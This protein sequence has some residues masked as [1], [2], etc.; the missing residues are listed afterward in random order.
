MLIGLGAWGAS[1]VALAEES[2]YQPWSGATQAQASQTRDQKLQ[3]LVTELNALTGMSDHGA[4][5][6]LYGKDPDGIEFE[7][8]WRL[9]REEWGEWE[10]A[11]P[12]AA[13]PA[14]SA[15][16]VGVRISATTPGKSC[17]TVYWALPT[18]SAR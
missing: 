1:G 18:S 15:P 16:L 7:V 14:I 4:T 6:S 3:S 9:P 8:L 5:K 12:A 2:T 13:I 11:A 10:R 17:S